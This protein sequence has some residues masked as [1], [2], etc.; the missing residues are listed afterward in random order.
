MAKF[1]PYIQVAYAVR[2]PVMSKKT[3]RVRG[4]LLTEQI[5]IGTPGTLEDW[6]RR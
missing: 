3:E 4:Q 6:C 5:V 2:D 1:L